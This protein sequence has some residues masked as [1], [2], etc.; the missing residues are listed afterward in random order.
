MNR[1]IINYSTAGGASWGSPLAPGS[2]Y[3]VPNAREINTTKTKTK[4]PLTQKSLQNP[5]QRNNLS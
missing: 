4:K 2:F 3:L 1:N 5:A